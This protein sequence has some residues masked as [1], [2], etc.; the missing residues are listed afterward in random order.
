MK[1]PVCQS[2]ATNLYST[3][4]TRAKAYPGLRELQVLKGIGD[5]AIVASICPANA[6]DALRADYAFRPAMSAF[7]RQVGI[8]IKT[9]F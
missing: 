4:Q 7:L 9:C 3:L 2:S 6:T 1:N 5:Q 8:S